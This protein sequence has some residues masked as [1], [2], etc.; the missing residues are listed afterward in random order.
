MELDASI[1]KRARYKAH[2]TRIDN[3]INGIQS[4]SQIDVENLSIRESLLTKYYNEYDKVQETIEDS[5]DESNTE[6]FNLH[7]ADREKT[8]NK[9]I[10]CLSKI[11]S[12][13]KNAEVGTSTS[14][15]SNSVLQGSQGSQSPVVSK[16][17]LP[18][19]NIPIFDG[20]YGE[21]RTFIDLFMASVNNNDKL[22]KS[23][24]FMYLKSFLK[25]EPLSLISELIITDASYDIALDI[26]R[27]HYDR[28]LFIINHHISGLLQATLGKGSSGLREFTLQIKQHINAL[29]ALEVKVYNNWD[30]LLI[31]ILSS[32]LDRQ[33]RNNYEL[34]RNQDT[35]PT[36]REFFE[37]LEKNNF[38]LGNKGFV[39]QAQ[40]QTVSHHSQASSTNTRITN[41]TYCKGLNHSIYKCNK[42]L[43][44]PVQEKR[45]FVYANKLC[46]NC[47]G[48][49]H[50]VSQCTRDKCRTCGG[51]HNTLIH[52]NRV[53]GE[54]SNTNFDI[55]SQGQQVRPQGQ[56]VGSQGQQVG[57]Q[58]QHS[59]H[60]VDSRE[61]ENN[62][63]HHVALITQGNS[64]NTPSH[65][66]GL[67]VISKGQVLLATATLNILSP[68]RQKMQI[69][70][71]LEGLKPHLYSLKLL[72][73]LR[74]KTSDIDL[75][76][77]GISQTQKRISKMVNITIEPTH[78]G[79][80]KIN[81]TCGVVDN[82]TCELPQTQINTS[83][84]T[85]PP[86][87]TLA[88]DR[89]YTPGKIHM[90]IG[91]DVFYDL[92]IPG[93][94][95]LGQGSPIL[96]NSKLGWV[97]GGT[98]LGDDSQAGSSTTLHSVVLHSHTLNDVSELVPKFWQ[99]EEISSKKVIS[100]ED[101][102]CENIFS[103]TTH[104]ENLE[105]KFVVNLPLKYE[106][107]NLGL[108]DSFEQAK[109]RFNNL[110]K[111]LELQT[112]TYGTNSAPFLATRCLVQLA[113]DGTSSHPLASHTL[114]KQC[115]VD[116][117]L[118]G[119]N[120]IEGLSELCKELVSLLGT[121]GFQLHKWVSN[122]DNLSEKQDVQIHFDKNLS[123]VLGIIWQPTS[124]YFKICGVTQ[125][126]NMFFSKRNILAEIAKLFD[127]L[128]FIGPVIVVGKI[129]IQ[130]Y[131]LVSS[132]VNID[133]FSESLTL[134]A[135]FSDFCKLQRTIAYCL[136][137]VHNS[138]KNITKYTGP[139]SVG[140]LKGSLTNRPKWAWDSVN[141]KEN[142][143]ILLCQGR[144][145]KVRVAKIKTQNGIYVRPIT[146]L[147][148]LPFS[149]KDSV[150][151]ARGED[152]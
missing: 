78:S 100:S 15:V 77:S 18:T 40:V 141:L 98:V 65:S 27:K 63:T 4:D 124:D 49:K 130:K 133:E 138:R 144:D 127:P 137:F 69:R 110:E 54:G 99:M 115:Y 96:S 88:D 101:K 5:L 80:E 64:E 107:N 122:V 120:S 30:L 91:A 31:H 52:E 108:G 56:Q 51:K 67:T 103:S 10:A 19:L 149:V 47:F 61:N 22:A 132:H 11:K 71:L 148:P 41:C 45:N 131:G 117:I 89:F 128:G 70:A 82:I 2:L 7:V 68:N 76:I 43:N 123:K 113:I 48:S 83:R 8:E 139:L 58:G 26:L 37:F 53:T 147:C 17:L 72:K 39:A 119:S 29:E 151:A 152:V 106:L 42:F 143:M 90:L 136:R 23:Q 145:G 94:I 104:Q 62:A 112:V 84:F 105:G 109:R 12:L 116:D 3:I 81:M 35:L 16:V 114:L 32:Q 44:L 20:N 86:N 21:W 25:N 50:S 66:Q 24:K 33:L 73:S 1:K 121:A 129:I 34:E 55:R 59:S 150:A 95:R 57:S 97:L 36:L 102:N 142:D 111:R 75:H 79:K 134:F 87:V 126:Q 14:G 135:K 60:N 6:Q 46:F 28:K 9:Y 118:A 92:I 146:K 38:S 93:I 13:I 125:S 140:E 74:L 85:I